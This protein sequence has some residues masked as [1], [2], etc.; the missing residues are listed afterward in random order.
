MDLSFSAGPVVASAWR[1]T[2]IV[3]ITLLVLP[4]LD[5]V[6]DVPR[7]GPLT[8]WATVFPPCSPLRRPFTAASAP[9]CLSAK[10]CGLLLRGLE[11]PPVRC[12]TDTLLLLSS[13]PMPD[14]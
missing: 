12:A 14:I 10:P 5:V 6:D 2:T 4:A 1:E 13:D 3:D 11:L 7:V 8:A 9:S